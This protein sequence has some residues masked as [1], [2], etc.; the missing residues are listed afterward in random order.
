MKTQSK[1]KKRRGFSLRPVPMKKVRLGIYWHAPLDRIFERKC[2]NIPHSSA[3]S[4]TKE[5]CEP[6][7]VRLGIYWHAPLDRIFKRVCFNIP[8]S[9]TDSSTKESCEPIKVQSRIS[10]AQC[11]FYSISVDNVKSCCRNC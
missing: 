10:V 9:S 11:V 4:S 5:S 1:G 6:G 7:K 3:D 8:H 2:F